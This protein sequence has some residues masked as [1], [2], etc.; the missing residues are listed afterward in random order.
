VRLII[1]KAA[2]DKTASFLYQTGF[3]GR[4]EIGLSGDDNLHIK[5]SGDGQD[6]REGLVIDGQSGRLSLPHTAPPSVMLNL[7]PDAGRF[8]GTP[9]PQGVIASSFSTPPYL[10]PYNGSNFEQGVPFI[11]N[12]ASY[13]GSAASLDTIMEEWVSKIKD[14]NNRRYG[15]EFFSLKITAGTGANGRLTV[16]GTDHYLTMSNQS[17]PISNQMSLT[18]YVYVVSGQIVIGDQNERY[19]DGVK[20]DDGAYRLDNAMGWKQVT[21]LLDDDAPT[22]LGYD[23]NLFRLYAT[24]NSVFYL[25]APAMMAGHLDPNDS[26][27]YGIIPGIRAWG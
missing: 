23:T 2:S 19:I 15:I 16:D 6:W 13:G 4:A 5:V 9:E 1:N 22:S 11:H 12:N 8:A 20:T 21:Y 10:S 3:E 14:I 26:E 7:F 17:A 25:A 18:F 24:P 27:Y